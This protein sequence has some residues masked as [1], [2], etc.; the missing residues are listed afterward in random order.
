MVYGLTN[1]VSH[2]PTL[3]QSTAAKAGAES[4]STSESQG[5]KGSFNAGEQ[6]LKTGVFFA[7]LSR[8][9]SIN[10]LVG[11]SDQ[12]F[13]MVP[14]VRFGRNIPMIQKQVKELTH[15]ALSPN[16]SEL[17]CLPNVERSLKSLK[18]ACDLKLASVRS[19]APHETKQLSELNV[20]L[21]ELNL[22]V[23]KSKL[24][25]SE[26][27]GTEIISTAQCLAK[28]TDSE[29]LTGTLQSTHHSPEFANSTVELLQCTDKLLDHLKKQPEDLAF[30]NEL[31]DGNLT[32]TLHNASQ[33]LTQFANHCSAPGIRADM[34]ALADAVQSLP[35][36]HDVHAL[37][38]SMDLNNPPAAP[39]LFKAKNF[40]YG[41][42]NGDV[43]GSLYFHDKTNSQRLRLCHIGDPLIDSMRK[44]SAQKTYFP[45]PETNLM[46]DWPESYSPA[47]MKAFAKAN[48]I[49]SK[50]VEGNRIYEYFDMNFF[51]THFQSKHPSRGVVDSV[52][53]IT[54]KDINL[55]Y[56]GIDAKLDSNQLRAYIDILIQKGH[57]LPALKQ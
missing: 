26:I 48:N 7:T 32:E 49:S 23:Q 46:R 31:V 18:N 4:S 11:L 20:A 14:D 35:P 12:L 3:T 39:G 50:P 2:T 16:C 34:T 15:L 5:S 42:K 30:L 25:Q 13:K 45:P 52:P 43:I 33:K 17:L 1:N 40:Q 44:V 28:L 47:K 56:Q 37:I 55:I 53:G 10:R 41:S 19:K 24:E 36:I 51:K 29:S 8:H 57:M 38:N 54:Q 21:D 9:A 22:I 27:P 6:W